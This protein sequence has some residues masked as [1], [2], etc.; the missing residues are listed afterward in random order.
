MRYFQKN[1]NLLLFIPFIRETQNTNGQITD[2]FPPHQF[3]VEY[4]KN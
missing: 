4:L 1:Y 2:Q 3:S